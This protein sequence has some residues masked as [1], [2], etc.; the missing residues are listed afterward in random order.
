[1][2]EDAARGQ[3]RGHPPKAEVYTPQEIGAAKAQCQALLKGLDVVVLEEPPIKSGSCGTPAPV[4]L[5]SVGRNPQVA[6]S[7]PVTVTC[8]MVAAMHKWVTQELQPL[9]KKISACRSSASTP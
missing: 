3:G 8:D 9:A 6:L 1:M 5:I 2:A 7:P 4:Q